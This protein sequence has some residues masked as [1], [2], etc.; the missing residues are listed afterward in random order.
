MFTSDKFDKEMEAIN[1]LREMNE[2]DDE[3]DDK[4]QMPWQLTDLEIWANYT[5]EL[6]YEL[7]IRVRK[8]LE[9]TA[10]G[11]RHY[12]GQTVIVSKLYEWI[13]GEPPEDKNG[14]VCRKLHEI[15]GYY[16][17]KR[18]GSTTYRGKRIPAGVYKL[19]TYEGNRIP[20][21]IRLRLELN[22][23]NKR[24][25]LNMKPSEN[26]SMPERLSGRDYKERKN[27]KSIS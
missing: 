18:T 10:A 19:R 22:E 4:E 26:W 1:K 6:L 27:G 9:A 8:F 15:M 14:I 17:S 12:K 13:F 23:G 21:S 25:S 20:Y 24:F 16:A 5:D 3:L 2:A 7:E 11:R